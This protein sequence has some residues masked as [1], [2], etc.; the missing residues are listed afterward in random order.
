MATNLG[1]IN[2]LRD[3]VSCGEEFSR[4]PVQRLKYQVDILAD[5]F[6]RFNQCSRATTVNY[7]EESRK[8]QERFM[9]RIAPGVD[10]SKAR[11]ITTS[12]ETSGNDVSFRI[13]L[14]AEIVLPVYHNRWS[15]IIEPTYQSVETDGQRPMTYSSIEIPVGVRYN[16]YVSDKAKVFVNAAGVIDFPIETK[17]K[18]SNSI[19]V[20]DIGGSFSLTAGAG[21]AYKRLSLE[22]RY[23][24]SRNGFQELE[25]LGTKFTKASLILGFRIL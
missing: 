16:F 25:L 15:I 5:Y 4:V 8:G 12:T 21:F 10:F 3:S 6:V 9:L 13:G 17:V 22:G 18:F 24:F 7:Y 20:E 2:Q 14:E 11:I 19:T 23:Y 1:Y